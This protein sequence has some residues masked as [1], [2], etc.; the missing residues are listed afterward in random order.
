MGTWSITKLSNIEFK[1]VEAEFYQ[2]TF[3]NAKKIAGTKSFKQFGVK[4]FHPAEVRRIYSDEGT[5][6]IVLAQNVRDNVMD[7]SSKR[8]MDKSFLPIISRNKLEEGDVLVTRSGANYGQTSVITIEPQSNNLFA[9][10]DVLILKSGI[11][12]GPL[13]STYLNS[14]I[15]K[16]LMNRGV[17]GAGQ[18]HIAPNYISEIPFPEFL[19]NNKE[20]VD[21]LVYKSRRL[22]ED[23]QTLYQQATALLEQELGLDKISFDKPKSYKAKFSEVVVNKRIDSD[24]YNPDYEKLQA[25]LK[26]LNHAKLKSISTLKSGFAFSSKKYKTFG[27]QIVRIQNISGDRINLKRNPIYYSDTDLKGLNNFRINKGDTLMAMTGNTIGNCSLNTTDEE[28]YLNQ[29]VLAVSPDL[30]Q[31]SAE[32]LNLVLRNVVFKTFI[33]RELVGGAQPNISLEF[34]S[35][36]I[37]PIVGTDRMKQISDLMKEHYTCIDTSNQLL[38]EAKNRVEQLIEAAANQ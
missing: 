32:Y 1:R 10:A 4:V 6:Q 5:L 9:C 18:P 37:I 27:K 33:E 24:F 8:M 16:T 36:Q 7:W 28:L 35:N 11:I 3:I 12:G 22:K 29:R 25:H 34:I 15:G 31:V 21:D 2:H 17:Y 26:T 20:E 23:S 38:Q 30:N 14:K 13:L 19:L